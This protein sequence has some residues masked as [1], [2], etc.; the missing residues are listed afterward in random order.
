MAWE[1]QQQGLVQLSALL[2]EFQKPGSNQ[3]QVGALLPPP[4]CL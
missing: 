4:Y 2:G 3:T 1:P